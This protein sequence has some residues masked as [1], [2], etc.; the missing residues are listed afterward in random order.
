M[1][2]AECRAGDRKDRSRERE[3]N[4]RREDRREK[5]ETPPQ[6]ERRTLGH[7]SHTPYA[8]EASKGG[9]NERR[10][11]EGEERR[12]DSQMPNVVTS[13]RRQ[14]T[15]TECKE[16]WRFGS[17]CAW[18]TDMEWKDV[19][20]VDVSMVEMHEAGCRCGM[21]EARGGVKDV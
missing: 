14:R 1:S 9:C 20:G 2:C 3:K 19:R 12:G 21:H 4:R 15:K 11:A 17:A 10:R 7:R 5:R 8:A 6:E 13:G 18:D 16:V